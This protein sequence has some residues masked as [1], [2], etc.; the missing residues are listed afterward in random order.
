M[1]FIGVYFPSFLFLGLSI[2]ASDVAHLEELDQNIKD[3]SI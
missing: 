3:D 1:L 2:F